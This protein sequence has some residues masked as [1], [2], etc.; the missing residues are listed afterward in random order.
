MITLASSRPARARVGFVAALL[1]AVLV[2][3]GGVA[4]AQAQSPAAPAAQATAPAGDPVVATVDGTPIRQSDLAQAEKDVGAAIPA[5]TEEAKRDW[6]VNYMTDMTLLAKQAEADKIADAPEF[7]ARLAYL[8]QKALMEAVLDK[9]G[10]EATSDEAMRH[11][12]QE[13]LKQMG[14]EQEVHARHILFRVPDAGDA[15]AAKKAEE[16]AKAALARIK[17]GEDFA[18]VAKEL[19][20]DPPGKQDG[21]DLG[22]FTKEQMVP[23]FSEA[24]FKLEEGQVSEPV[25]TSFGWH[26]I[27]VEGKR[28]RQPPTFEQVKEQIETFVT[29]KAQIDLV[30]KLR[31]DAKIV[32]LDKPADAAKPDAAKPDAA[33]SDAGKAD[34]AKPDAGKPAPEKK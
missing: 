8:R 29:R 21:G 14:D 31:N 15:E 13:A 1:A 19:T 30:N 2:P 5:G 6:L 22:W 26:I 3:A 16:A 32:R 7:K 23:P 12:Y 9:T 20:D 11:V 34:A 17:K 4:L 25:K 27:K 28:K 10:A 18:K 33:K 24:A